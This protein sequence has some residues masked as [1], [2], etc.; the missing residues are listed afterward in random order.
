MLAPSHE[1]MAPASTLSS[2]ISLW[3]EGLFCRSMKVPVD[4]M[5]ATAKKFWCS[6]G[7]LSTTI[8]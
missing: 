8:L 7:S 4:Q 2:N 6:L 5:M 1:D 3:E